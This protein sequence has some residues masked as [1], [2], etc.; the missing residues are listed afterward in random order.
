LKILF[1]S[2]RYSGGIGG[3][4]AMLADQLQKYGF[5]IDFVDPPKIP[6]KNLK[7]PSFVITSSVS[8]F[9][10]GSY[11]IVHA[12]NVPSAFAMRM[13]RAKKRILSIHG[14]FSDQVN[15]L[16]SSALG[17]LAGVTEE[18][19]LKW[20]DALTTDSK[21]SQKTYKEKLGLDFVY[22]PSPIDTTKFQ[23]LGNV[24]KKENQIA[25]IGRDSYEKGI[26]ILRQIEPKIK[27]KVVYST[28]LPWKEA[29]RLLK[30]SDIIVIP[31][32]MESLP[33]VVK[34]AFYLKVPVIST[35]VGGIPEL[36]IN[37]TTGILVPPE[38]PEKLLE[39][40][41]NLL[42]N[43]EYA[44]KLTDAAY[45]FVVDNMTWD[46]ILPKYVKFYES[47]LKS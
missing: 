21:A 30:S 43:K 22:M 42:Q 25:Y 18:S 44:K 9:F 20:A 31:S 38:S 27:G 23:D 2:P 41:N 46:T 14:V 10:K 13:A 32:R 34:E 1:I 15:V 33:T 37:G 35:S 4:A 29:M 5:Q 11:D 36:V 17:E 24:D 47:L 8:S 3:H 39:E 26:D 7:N 45:D 6:I 16:H 28:N 40:I 19:V 12:F